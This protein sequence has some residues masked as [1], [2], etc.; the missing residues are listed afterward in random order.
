[1]CIVVKYKNKVTA[2]YI[3]YW[4]L[5][6]LDVYIWLKYFCSNF[7]QVSI[8]SNFSLVFKLVSI[9]DNFVQLGHFLL[10]P[11]KSLMAINSDCHMS[12]RDFFKIIYLFLI[13]FKCSSVNPTMCHV[14]KSIFYI[15][16]VPY[17]CY[18]CSI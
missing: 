17:I 13:F 14:S 3:M 5:I 4:L 15:Q 10:T 9:F 18:F 12:L 2:T 1:M 8:R 11:F 6:V 16:F 7:R